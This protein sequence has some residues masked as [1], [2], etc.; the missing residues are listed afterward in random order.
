MH[1]PYICPTIANKIKYYN[2]YPI[3]IQQAIKEEE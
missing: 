3:K 2:R 1:N